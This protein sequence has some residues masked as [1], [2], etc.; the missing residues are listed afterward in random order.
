M[1]KNSPIPAGRTSD[2]NRLAPHLIAAT[3]TP[4]TAGGA[5]DCASLRRLIADLRQGGIDEFFVAGSTGEA[6]LLDEPDR[7][8]IIETVRAAAPKGRVYAGVSGTG[9][10]HAIRNAQYAARAGAD[11]A[12]LMSPY[13]V[14]LDQTQLETF[15]LAVADA[16]PIPVAI[17]HHLRM[18]TPVA[19]PTIARLAAHPNIVAI[20]DTNGSDHDRCAEILAAT[21]GRPFQFFQGVEKLVLSTLEAGGH[22]C[23]VAQAC[24][25]PRLFRALFDAWQ[26]GDLAH[27]QELQRRIARLWAVFSRRDVKQSFF[28]FLHTLKLPLHQRGILATTA[29]AL[30]VTFDAEFDQAITDFMREHLGAEP[31]IPVA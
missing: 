24:I 30:Q 3:V 20:K 12:V 6:P 5:V 15:C 16:S 4:F 26:A 9:Q 14:A 23:V 22:G 25:A 8:A 7:L 17:Y 10:G 21:A 1:T 31:A 18:P 29:S 28:H 13:F 11:V 19:V 27:A 2:G